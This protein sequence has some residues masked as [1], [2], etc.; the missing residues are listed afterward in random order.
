MEEDEVFFGSAG[1]LPPLHRL[2]RGAGRHVHAQPSRQQQQT[3]RAIG[4]QKQRKQTVQLSGTYNLMGK[5]PAG[6]MQ[7]QILPQ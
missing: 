6:G 7:T 3:Q 4:Q 1:L 2:L 5:P